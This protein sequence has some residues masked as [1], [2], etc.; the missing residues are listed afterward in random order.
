MVSVALLVIQIVGSVITS[1]IAYQ[2]YIAVYIIIHYI[3][4]ST[5][6][7]LT[8]IFGKMVDI[9]GGRIKLLIS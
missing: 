4:M 2:P 8:Y 5:N 7:P 9:D 3:W 1:G 6:L